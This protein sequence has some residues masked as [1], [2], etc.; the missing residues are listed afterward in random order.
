MG[1]GTGWDYRTGRDAEH[2][3]GWGT[4]REGSG[5]RKHDHDAKDEDEDNTTTATAAQHLLSHN[6]DSQTRPRDGMR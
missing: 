5:N 6:G 4:E 2:E 1:G 3:T